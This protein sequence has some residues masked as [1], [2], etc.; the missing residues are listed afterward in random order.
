MWLWRSCFA[1]HRRSFPEINS[2]FVSWPGSVLRSRMPVSWLP[3]LYP[4]LT[5]IEMLSVLCRAR[6]TEH[7]DFLIMPNTKRSQRLG[8]ARVA[9]LQSWHNHTLYRK[10]NSWSSGWNRAGLMPGGSVCESAFSVIRMS[11]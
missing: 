4:F 9:Y 2:I 7:P 6:H 3:V 8:G 11:A 1:L 5:A 10:A